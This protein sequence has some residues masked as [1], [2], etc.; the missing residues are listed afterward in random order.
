[1]HQS[2]AVTV[3]V[4]SAVLWGIGFFAV[5]V[6]AIV[7]YWFVARATRPHWRH[8]WWA[9]VGVLAAGLGILTVVDGSLVA[10]RAFEALRAQ[11]G[12]PVTYT[13][14][15]SGLTLKRDGTA[16]LTKVT[17]ADGVIRNEDGR[18]CLSGESVSI[19]GGGRWSLTDNGA[20]R[21]D[22]DGKVGQ[23]FPDPKSLLGY[24]WARAYLLTSCDVPTA[25]EY[26]ASGAH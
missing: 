6:L 20:V 2:Y 16:T 3:M 8:P 23:L 26:W 25:T 14:E 1:M 17:L 5:I 18:W 22:I 15:T 11:V 4:D 9:V 21:I 7:V 19:S 10:P 24:G 13:S 12:L